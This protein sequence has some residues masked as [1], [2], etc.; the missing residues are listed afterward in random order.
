MSSEI[1][2]GLEP[3]AWRTHHDEPMLFPTFDEAAMYCDDEEP[4]EPLYAATAIAELVQKRDELLAAREK[5]AKSDPGEGGCY[6]TNREN[7]HTARSAVSFAKAK[8]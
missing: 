7:I 1:L 5:I 6:Y 8:P 3:G 4:P 2:K